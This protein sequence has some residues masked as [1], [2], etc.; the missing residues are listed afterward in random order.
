MGNKSG[1]KFSDVVVLGKG[2]APKLAC[3]MHPGHKVV[4]MVDR[5]QDQDEAA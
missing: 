1:K 5:H 4:G 3:G 2:Y